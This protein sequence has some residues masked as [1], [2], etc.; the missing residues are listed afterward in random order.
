MSRKKKVDQIKLVVSAQQA[1]PAPPV[2][3]ALGRKKLNIMQFCKTFNDLTKNEEKGSPIPVIVEIY[4]DNTF[5]LILKK[6]PVS[7]LLLRA[8]GLKKGSNKTGKVDP[9]GKLSKDDCIKIAKDKMEEMNTLELDNA[10]K[11]V[12][13]SAK[14]MGI[15]IKE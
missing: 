1:N 4:K 3:P 10:V 6:P 8:L 13:G 12:M 7:Y 9:I 11:T 5:S 15:S 2:G 14:S